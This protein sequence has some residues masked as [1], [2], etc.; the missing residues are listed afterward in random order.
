MKK[1]LIAL[2]ACA[3]I[4]SLVMPL[5]AETLENCGAKVESAAFIADMSGSMMKT[6]RLR[7]KAKLRK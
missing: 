6:F 5:Q 3:A 7:L 4:N 2:A 1:T